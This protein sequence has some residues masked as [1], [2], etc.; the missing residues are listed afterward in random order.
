MSEGAISALCTGD[1]T[2]VRT[3]KGMPERLLWR[4]CTSRTAEVSVFLLERGLRP[5]RAQRPPVMTRRWPG[6]DPYRY[7]GPVA[8][9]LDIGDEQFTR[10]CLA[11]ARDIIGSSLRPLN[12]PRS[13]WD[14]E[15]DT[16]TAYWQLAAGEGKSGLGILDVKYLHDPQRRRRESPGRGLDQ[17][18]REAIRGNLERFQR[19]SDD[20]PDGR[21]PEGFIL[22][23]NA[24]L[25]D[26]T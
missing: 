22:A 7:D 16:G 8:W 19:E 11:L 25:S 4:P 20:W 1:G 5:G 13:P 26:L 21:R 17:W 15:F 18:Y 14:A 10:L 24:S 3:V 9:N 6:P 12:S 2:L 23:T